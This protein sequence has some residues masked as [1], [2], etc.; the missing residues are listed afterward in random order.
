VPPDLTLEL[1]I[2]AQCVRCGAE[3]ELE[4]QLVAAGEHVTV[5]EASTACKACGERRV[6]VTVGVEE[7]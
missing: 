2:D 5:V 7:T 6:K 3:R 1:D 4:G